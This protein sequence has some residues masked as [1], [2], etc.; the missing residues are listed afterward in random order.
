[1]LKHGKNAKES[2]E[3]YKE[4]FFFRN[5]LPN[6]KKSQKEKHKASADFV[7]PDLR[8]LMPVPE[9]FLPESDFP[10]NRDFPDFFAENGRRFGFHRK[11][12]ADIDPFQSETFV[13][14]EDH[15]FGSE[16][17]LKLKLEDDGNRPR[18]DFCDLCAGLTEQIPAK[19]FNLDKGFVNEKVLTTCL[20]ADDFQIAIGTNVGNIYIFNR[21]LRK[22]FTVKGRVSFFALKF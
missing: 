5:R 8:F 4:R 15:R 13:F 19:S 16:N 21:R 9:I 18:F 3:K 6:R 17:R 12:A 22:M 11:M 7:I 14:D 20:D 2:Q 1:M 10:R